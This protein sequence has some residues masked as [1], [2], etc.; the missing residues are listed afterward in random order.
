VVG[1]FGPGTPITASA[2]D[3]LELMLEV[4]N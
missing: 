3:I 4:Y 2:K 1:V